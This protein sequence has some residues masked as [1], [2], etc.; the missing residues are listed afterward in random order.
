MN[1][2]RTPPHLITL[3]L[4]T[5]FS[6]MSLN[7]FLPSLANIAVDLKTDYST[8][9]WAVSGYL[10][11]TAI[12]QLIIGPLSDRT[13]RR[14]VLL[15]ALL[16][17]A[18]ASVGCTFAS[19]IEAFLFC[20]ML[21]G[22]IIGG[23]AL[24]LAIVR[25]MRTEREAVSLIGYIGM[26]MAIAPMIG[27][28]L[29]GVL[30]TFFG[31]RSVFGFYAAAGFGLLLLC[32]FDLGETRPQ[33]A[34]DTS[35]PVPDTTA[36]IREPLFWAYALC[37]TLSVGAFYI[38]L[39]GA[40]LVAQSTFNVTTAELG[41]YIGT[42]TVGFLIGGFLAGRVGQH[43]EPTTIMIAG[44]VVACTGLLGGLL[45]LASG[46]RSAEF[47]F[48]S[49]LFVGLGNGITM[50]GCNAGA[51][52]VRP[53]LAGSAAGLSGALIVAGG[54]VLTSLTGNLVPL[55]NGG[56]TLLM[57][58]LATSGLAMAFAVWAAWLKKKGGY[59]ARSIDP[60]L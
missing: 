35:T 24:S 44:R 42:I 52:S 45:L 59:P 21:Q 30:D 51:M 49:T 47:F 29:G 17:F 11:L 43:F 50:P 58:M 12:I 10:A 37:G 32:W 54:A 28:M 40:P 56:Q 18:F 46:I 33:R 13:G 34:T 60:S 27:P 3:I 55:T 39:T 57:L 31:W 23:Y 1:R 7:M 26:A 22:G 8:V 53:D 20:R 4:L 38:F 15:G 2:T 6:P 48:A 41:L 19:N 25:D 5:G 14:R 9:S 36:L 16:V